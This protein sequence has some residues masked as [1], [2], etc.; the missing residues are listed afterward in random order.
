MMISAAS[1]SRVV[2]I[3]LDCLDPDLVFAR[4]AAD[5]PHLG[6]LRGLWGPLRSSVPPITVPAWACM[7]TSRDPGQLGLYGFSGRADWSYEARHLA[8]SLSYAPP[9]VWTLLSRAGRR[10]RVLGVPQTWPPKPLRG[11]LCTGFLTPPGARDFTYP[12]ELAGELERRFGPILFDADDHRDLSNDALVASIRALTTQRFAIALDWAA[13]DDW[14]FFMLVDMGPDR[15]HHAF[16]GEWPLLRD[17]Y[18]ELDARVGELVAALRSDDVVLVVSDHGAQAMRGGIALNEWLR[19][20][21]YLVLRDE[22]PGPLEPSRVDWQRTRAWADGGYVGR[23]WFNQRGREPEGI[24][25]D[26]E[27]LAR[28][29]ADGLRELRGIDGEPL[30]TRSWRPAELYRDTQGVP[31]DLTVYFDDLR[32]RALGSIGLPQLAQRANDTGRD[33]ANHAPDGVL[34]ARG[35]G[36]VGRRDD[37]TLYDV[38]PTVLGRLGVQAPQGMV[39]RAFP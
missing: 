33:A 25:G 30:A 13:R 20:A 16:W 14:D 37:L 31:P 19:R 28:E 39:G 9:P 11:S 10:C 24:V 5:L 12:A 32:Y 2:L 6:A 1:M 36:A 27:A 17:Y 22:T 35:L 8:S 26:A 15:M 21:G 7:L 29:L 23:I 34:I 3:G 38:A 18:V 4:F